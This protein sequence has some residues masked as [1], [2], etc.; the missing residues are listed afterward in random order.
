MNGAAPVGAWQVCWLGGNVVSSVGGQSEFL[1]P[2]SGA[3][4][5]SAAL[6]GAEVVKQISASLRTPSDE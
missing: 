5:V 4:M 6:L 1:G 2:V 3:L